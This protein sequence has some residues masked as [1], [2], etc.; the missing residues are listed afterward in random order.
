MITIKTDREI[1]LMYKAGQVAAEALALGGENVKPGVTTK[2]I[3]DVME[4]FIKSKGGIPSF[5]GYGGFPATACISINN[6]VIHGIPSANRVIA[7][8][9][10]VSIDVGVL[11]NGYHGDTARTYGAGNISKEAQRL[12]DVTKQ[13]FF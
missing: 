8:G 11:L 4:R 13:S 5:K 6:Q 10:I 1:E 9:D 2:H 12:I 3:N 7:D